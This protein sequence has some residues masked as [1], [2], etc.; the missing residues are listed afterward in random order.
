L[1]GIAGSRFNGF[2]AQRKPVE[3]GGILVMPGFTRL[4]P[5]ADEKHSKS[6]MHPNRFTDEFTFDRISS[7]VGACQAGWLN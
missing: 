6:E 4:K 1:P 7:N 2:R 5:G 3:T